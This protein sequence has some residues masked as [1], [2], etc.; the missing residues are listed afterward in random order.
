MMNSFFRDLHYAARTLLKRPLF[1][2]VAICS[3]ALGIGINAT[4]FSWVERVL[5]RPLPGVPDAERVVVLKTVAPNG[6]LLDS[7]YPDLQDFQRQTQSFTGILAYRHEPLFLGDI[8]TGRRVWSEMVSGNFFDVL[9]VKPLLGRTFSRDEQ[10]DTPGV[11]AVAVISETLWRNY[12]HSDPAIAGK[13]IELNQHPF[14]IVGVVPAAFQG[15]IDGLRFDLWV[16]VTMLSELTGSRYWVS[17]RNS[18]PLALMARLKPGADR[19]QA[20]AE[21]QTVAKRLALQY[22]D[23]NRKLSAA[24]LPMSDAPDGV[25]HILGKLQKILLVIAGAVLLIICANVGNLLLVQASARNKEFAIRASLGASPSRL[26]RQVF[27]EALLLAV[28]GSALGLLAATW[29]IRAI[30][31]F[32]PVTV[33][34]VSNLASDGIQ[35]LGVL[36][37]CAVGLLTAVLCGMVPALQLLLRGVQ[38]A[39][40]DGG[41]TSSAGPRARFFRAT[42]VVC[43]LSLALLALIGT[44]LF[45]RSFQNAKSAYPGFE[46]Q[47]VLL[48][49]LDFSQVRSPLVERVAYFRRLRDQ[50][51]LIP[52]VR[53]VSLSQDVPLSLEGGSWEGIEVEG[54]TPAPGENMK[55]WRN[56]VSPGYFRT[57]EVP[58]V[59]GR[60]FL[61][62]DDLTAPRVAIVNE[63][64]AK[65]FFARGPAIG[66]KIR[67]WNEDVTIVGIARD[68][69]YLQLNEPALPYFYLPLSQF[70]RPGSGAAVE[71]RLA[72][73]PDSFADPVR[74][75]IASVNPHVLISAIVPFTDYMSGSYF[76]QKV[77]AGLLSVLGLLS[78]F[79]AVL[80]LY[81]VM[82]YSI[83]QRTN[84]IG[85]RMALG[86]RPGQVLRLVL[87]EGLLLCLAGV[88]F[89]LIPSFLLNRIAAGALYGSRQN[90]VWIYIAAGL[91]LTACALLA[92]WVPARRAALTDPVT[93]LRWE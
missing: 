22:P 93:A 19:R 73:K 9:G 51:A 74:S 61:H 40:R 46:P 83:A 76:A 65:R 35:G 6:D 71:L 42:L 18:R 75:R 38:T 17:E 10:T 7:S 90:D 72:G 16:P 49:G 47:G 82:A 63:T 43:E 32:I 91:L 21:V 37:T 86:A 1:A 85:I 59:S 4:V 92:S 57:L 29:M 89:G 20:Q 84:E 25:Q 62:R 55:L 52:G 77:G 34:P 36:F 64:F 12:F 54:Y 87:R 33:L 60:E 44:G 48:A 24:V 5:L 79:L 26:I 15:T 23:S 30:Q 53:S 31:L 3:L 27:A 39:L 80:G 81:G 68:G 67:M 69:K 13:I 11:A 2:G 41:R 45:I 56:L 50:L 66:R 88:A 78:L 58:I 70:Y 8:A 14:T 28:A